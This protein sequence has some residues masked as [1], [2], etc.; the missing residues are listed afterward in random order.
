MVRL[1]LSY[2]YPNNLYESTL[3]LKFFLSDSLKDRLNILC[4]TYPLIIILYTI[5]LISNDRL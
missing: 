4:Y 5:L 2:T 3:I 1:E